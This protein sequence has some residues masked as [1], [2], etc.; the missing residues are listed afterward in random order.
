M[1]AI[2]L[3]GHLLPPRQARKLDAELILDP[4]GFLSL[5]S[6]EHCCHT[7]LQ[8]VEVSSAI[9]NLA[10][11]LTFEGGWVFVP[12]E[13]QQLN[14]WLRGQNQESLLGK[15]E[16]HTLMVLLFS[17]L[18]IAAAWGSYRFLLPSGAKWIAN[19]LPPAVS[20]QLGKE[21][22]ESL[23]AMGFG[24]S[25]LDQLTQDQ[26]QARFQR[27]LQS[28]TAK[29]VQT[30][31]PLKLRLVGQAVAED[32]DPM[33]NAF[34]LVDGTLVLT[35]AMVAL[36]E[37]P[38]ELEAVLL[39]EVGH[40]YHNHMLSSMVQSTLLSVVV[41]VVVGDGSGV[42]DF[43]SGAAVLGLTLGYSRDNERE[44]DA[45]AATQLDGFE[46]GRSPMLS[47]YQKLMTEEHGLALPAWLSTHPDLQERLQTLGQANSAAD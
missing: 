46:W 31:Q 14:L 10:R 30:P 1:T 35:D 6:A 9:G 28:L 18:L 5:S 13:P 19:M 39:H 2:K 17:V 34:A 37:A 45:F 15:L 4:R 27:L 20:E 25:K 12:R 22:F 47:L 44:A 40:V 11:Q 38:G 42:T 33:A 41:A 7:H 21:S 26:V 32:E 29:G 8:Q 43:L 36:A 24:D 23:K 3:K 16:R